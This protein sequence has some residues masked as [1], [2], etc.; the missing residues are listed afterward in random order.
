MQ[1]KGCNSKNIH[2]AILYATDVQRLYRKTT[3][4]KKI[5]VIFREKNSPGKKS[6]LNFHHILSD[7][8]KAGNPAFSDRRSVVFRHR[9]ATAVAF[10]NFPAPTR[11]N[12][13][14]NLIHHQHNFV[15]L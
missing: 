14:I 5:T 10:I 12:H 13:I 2:V 3:D 1:L 15:N 8:S 11:K 7:W 4:D 9:L 6:Q